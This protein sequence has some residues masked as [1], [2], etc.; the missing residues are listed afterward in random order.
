MLNISHSLRFEVLVIVSVGLLVDKDT[1][2][3]EASIFGGGAAFR[4]GRLLDVVVAC[5]FDALVL[6]AS[7]DRDCFALRLRLCI[8]MIYRLG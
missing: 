8:A 6:G 7:G 5:G 1:D 2:P 4:M 3:L